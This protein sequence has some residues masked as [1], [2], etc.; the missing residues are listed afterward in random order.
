MSTRT[1]PPQV[2]VEDLRN[3]I[4]GERVVG[5]MAVARRKTSF[6]WSNCLGRLRNSRDLQAAG[7]RLTRRGQVTTIVAVGGP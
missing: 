7:G 6:S 5:E 2:V 4:W 1:S 3:V